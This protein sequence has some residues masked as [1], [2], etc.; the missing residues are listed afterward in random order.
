[1][2]RP[3]VSL[4]DVEPGFWEH[5]KVTLMACRVHINT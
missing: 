1:M 4:I 5:G 2:C 3:T